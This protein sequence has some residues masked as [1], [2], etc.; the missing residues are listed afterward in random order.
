MVREVL[1]ATVERNTLVI[2]P[3]CKELRVNIADREHQIENVQLGQV[4]EVINHTFV[5]S[6]EISNHQMSSDHVRCLS[7]AF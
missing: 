2:Q 1:I 7:N 3:E 6:R 4:R 5:E